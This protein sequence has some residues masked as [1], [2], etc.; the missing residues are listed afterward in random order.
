M[1]H[2]KVQNQA[3]IIGRTDGAGQNQWS[4]SVDATTG[5][6]PRSRRPTDPPLSVSSIERLPARGTPNL[7][8]DPANHP[9]QAVELLYITVFMQL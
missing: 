9:T 8:P 4:T 7:C 5:A 2:R 3:R 6:S 1:I